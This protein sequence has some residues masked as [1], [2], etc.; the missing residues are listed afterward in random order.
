MQGL[1]R[2]FGLSICLLLSTLLVN[3]HGVVILEQTSVYLPQCVHLSNFDRGFQEVFRFGG[4]VL[5]A[6]F[7]GGRKPEHKT[8]PYYC[9]RP[10]RETGWHH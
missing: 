5:V 6:A 3:I 2:L 7:G 8:R 9:T 4:G 1:K 10:R